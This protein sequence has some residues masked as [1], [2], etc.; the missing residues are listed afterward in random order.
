AGRRREKRG[1]TRPPA[2]S[3][4]ENPSRTIWAWPAAAGSG[5]AAGGFALST[6]RL[7]VSVALVHSAVPPTPVTSGSEAGHS[8]VGPGIVEPPWPTGD[9]RMFAVPVSPAAPSTVTPLAA[10]ALNA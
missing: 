3:P 5:R 8:T 4:R 10:A 7:A 9:L 6:P 2:A 1:E